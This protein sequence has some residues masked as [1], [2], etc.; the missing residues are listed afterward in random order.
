M[1]RWQLS[2]FRS[3]LDNGYVNMFLDL[4]KQLE[5]FLFWLKWEQRTKSQTIKFTTN[6]LS[7]HNLIVSTTPAKH[8]C[9]MFK[10]FLYKN[11]K[12]TQIRS[13][14]KITTLVF[15]INAFYWNCWKTFVSYDLKF[16]RVILLVTGTGRGQ[17][18]GYN[19]TLKNWMPLTTSIQKSDL[20]FRAVNSFNANERSSILLKSGSF[21]YTQEM[22]VPDSG[23]SGVPSWDH[24]A[25]SAEGPERA[26]TACPLLLI[27]SDVLLRGTKW[28]RK[29]G[30]TWKGRHRLTERNRSYLH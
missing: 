24:T 23:T 20:V 4:Q 18:W 14:Q 2:T 21:D 30:R 25:T 13:S 6:C 27:Q 17:C 16:E 12:R 26:V 7:L 10:R 29:A 9:K 5:V 19:T 15:F 22:L 8:F 28:E 1:T 11:T 3:S